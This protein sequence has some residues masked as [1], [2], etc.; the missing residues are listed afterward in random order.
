MVRLRVPTA[1]VATLVALALASLSSAPPCRAE[2]TALRILGAHDYIVPGSALNSCQLRFDATRPSERA[3][4]RVENRFG[5]CVRRFTIA[6][7]TRARLF[8]WDGCDEHGR[9]LTPEDAPY[10][11]RLRAGRWPAARQDVLSGLGLARWPIAVHVTDPLKDNYASGIDEETISTDLV[12][13]MLGV[14]GGSRR[15]ARR[16][17]VE[18]EG[19]GAA[20][21]PL[22]ERGDRF[23][24]YTTPTPR[25]GLPDIRYELTMI[26]L[27]GGVLD[28]ATNPFDA[29][30]NRPGTQ[31][32]FS[33][34]FAVTPSGDMQVSVRRTW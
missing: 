10:T 8:S 32:G 23:P 19:K 12:L 16:Y 24:M 21:W 3:V 33:D 29:D 17:D 26:V 31:V 4:L 25:L 28:E 18:E 34:I 7:S 14:N 6:P 2:V 20:I 11:Y 22:D 30:D 1:F 5:E 9:S 15:I 13:I 27:P